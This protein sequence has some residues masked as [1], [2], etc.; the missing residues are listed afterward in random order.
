MGIY[1]VKYIY[2]IFFLIFRADK[3]NETLKN[4]NSDYMKMKEEE[5]KTDLE[6]LTDEHLKKLLGEQNILPEEDCTTD[7]LRK[8]LFDAL[9]MKKIKRYFNFFRALYQRSFF[10]KILTFQFYKIHIT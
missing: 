6:G 4:E 1:R 3:E 8:Q 2:T 7:S 5:F 10:D 9:C